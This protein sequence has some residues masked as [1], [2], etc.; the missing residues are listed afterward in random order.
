CIAFCTWVI[1]FVSHSLHSI[2][3]LHN[4]LCRKSS[5]FPAFYFP[6]ENLASHVTV[7][8]LRDMKLHSFTLCFWVQAQNR[9]SQTILSYCTQE[10]DNEL[11]VTVGSAVGLWVGGHFVEFPLHHRSEEWLHYCV[12]WASHSGTAYLWINGAVGKEN[13]LQRGYVSQPGGKLVLGKDRDELLGL[14]SNGFTGRMSYLNLWSWVLSHSDIRT[15]ALCKHS[16][17]KGD[18]I[19]WGETSMSLSGGVVLVSD[20]SCR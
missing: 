10:R 11:M 13:H 8:P 5:A 17:L 4:F 15:L 20:L 16:E 2:F 7:Q 12:A 6:A 9:D 3:L 19:S 1:L 14:F 18:V